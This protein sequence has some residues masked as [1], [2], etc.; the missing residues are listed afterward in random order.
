MITKH[1]FSMRSIKHIILST[2]LAAASLLPVAMDA[3][4]TRTV[5]DTIYNPKIVFTASPSQYE[6]AGIRVEGVDNYDENMIIG[7]SGLTVGQRV[8]IPGDE[9]KAAPSCSV[10]CPTA[11]CSLHVLHARQQRQ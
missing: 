8:D 4:E 9:I 3:Q 6:I 2:T 11:I 5:N 7:Y 10:T 1:N